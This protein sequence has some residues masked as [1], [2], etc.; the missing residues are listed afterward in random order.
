MLS[1]HAM[2]TSTPSAAAVVDASLDAG[3]AAFVQQQ[4]LLDLNRNETS[5]KHTNNSATSIAQVES[6]NDTLLS[7]LQEQWQNMSTQQRQTYTNAAQKSQQLLKQQSQSQQTQHSHSTTKSNNNNSATNASAIVLQPPPTSPTISGVFDF[8]SPLAL[9]SIRSCLIR[10]EESIIFALIERAQFRRN[11]PIYAQHGIVAEASPDSPLFETSFLSFFLRET[12]SLHAKTR[13]YTSPDEHPFTPVHELPQ[14]ILPALHYPRTVAPSLHH[15]I[16]I[17]SQIL[18]W[19]IDA[20]V[21]SICLPG[22]DQNYGSAATCDINCLQLLSKRIHYGKFVAESKYRQDPDV[23]RDA[24]KRRDIGALTLLITK[25]IVEEAVLRRVHTKAATY[26]SEPTEQPLP[27]QQQQQSSQQQQQQPDSNPST[28]GS[29]SSRRCSCSDR[30]KRAKLKVSPDAIAEIYAR[31][32]TLTKDVQIEYLLKRL[33][34]EQE[35]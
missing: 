32:M 31:V 33:E 3:F 20:V 10:L 9:E 26:G 35:S 12:E 24:I 27:Q 18:D 8:Y 11:T 21:P 17:N 6:H 29:D 34:A 28:L 4:L 13:R 15:S 5:N 7:Q 25:P 22:D 19:Y 30:Q 1:P 23:F 2:A 16:N 14:P